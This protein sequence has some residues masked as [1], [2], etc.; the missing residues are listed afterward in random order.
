[1]S[2]LVRRREVALHVTK[3]EK[4]KKK[5]KKKKFHFHQQLNTSYQLKKNEYHTRTAVKNQCRAIAIFERDHV[6]WVQWCLFSF[7]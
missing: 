1:M 5:K 6:T 3:N 4:R 2:Y 7:G